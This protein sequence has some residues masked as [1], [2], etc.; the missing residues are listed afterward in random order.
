VH[1][2]RAGRVR[3][4]FAGDRARYIA[5][6]DKQLTW[7]MWVGLVFGVLTLGLAFIEK[8]PGEAVVKIVA[9]AIWFAVA[10]TTFIGR[11]QLAGIVA[12][13]TAAPS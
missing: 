1:K 8:R 9:A 13:R 4:G 11:R 6:F 3:K 12:D 7:L 10:G 2:I 5:A